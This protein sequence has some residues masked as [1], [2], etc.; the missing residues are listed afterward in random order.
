[1]G[2]GLVEPPPPGPARPAL[3]GSAR[4]LLRRGGRE[5]PGVGPQPGGARQALLRGHDAVATGEDPSRAAAAVRGRHLP[6]ARR[7]RGHGDGAH[8]AGGLGGRGLLARAPR[9]ACARGPLIPAAAAGPRAAG[10]ERGERPDGGAGPRGRGADCRGQPGPRGRRAARGGAPARG[11][12]AAVRGEPPRGEAH[13]P[14]SGLRPRGAAP[15][16]GV[17]RH[18]RAERDGPGAGEGHRAGHRLRRG[19]GAAPPAPPPR[20]TSTGACARSATCSS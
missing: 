3:G 8:R 15:Q 6:G 7:A 1:M 20:R 12:G 19:G 9:R 14:E 4:A 2:S 18:E 11:R 5:A 13:G 10:R 17:P 16:R